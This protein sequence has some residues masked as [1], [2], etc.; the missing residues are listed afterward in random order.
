MNGVAA[1]SVTDVRLAYGAT[2]VLK[3]TSLEVRHGEML[4]LVGPNGAGKSTLL[5]VVSGVLR[6]ASGQVCVDGVALNGLSAKERARRVAVV[7]QN[8]A[9]PPGFSSL[10][11]VLM[12]R[13]PHLGLLQWES[14]NDIDACKR[15]MELT[16]TWE[17][18]ERPVASLSGGERQRVFIARAL[19]Q[20]TDLLLLD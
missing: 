12:G 18:A 6:P 2:E 16:G 14:S 15:A 20:E 9:V 19:A 13:N 1:L 3:G 11:V 4:C 7:A 17:F 5:N 10:D 8:P